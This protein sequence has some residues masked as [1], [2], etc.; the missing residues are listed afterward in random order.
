MEGGAG[1]S[2]AG[3]LSGAAVMQGDGQQP[4]CKP[5]QLLSHP[6]IPPLPQS[7]HCPPYRLQRPVVAAQ[8][9]LQA[10]QVL[11]SR[12]AWPVKTAALTTLKPAAGKLH[13]MPDQEGFRLGMCMLADMHGG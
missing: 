6:L 11:Q 13:L 2:L 9:L 5:S 1:R 4:S 8:Q 3:P 10:A 7:N 12:A